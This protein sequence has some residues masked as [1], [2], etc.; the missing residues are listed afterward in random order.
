MKP[1]I[2]LI[3][4]LFVSL[5]SSPSW[6][7]SLT[8]DDLIQ[9][10]K[11]YYEKFSNTPFTGEITGKHTGKFENGLREGPYEIYYKSGQLAMETTYEDGLTEGEWTYYYPDGNIHFRG[12]FVKGKRHGE[13]FTY[14][15]FGF[16]PEVKVYENGT[17]VGTR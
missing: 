3:T 4:I 15:E 16:P 6:S 9:R 8:I 5:L 17:V 10:N 11:L 2:T 7:E 12:T 14:D 1:I 13:F